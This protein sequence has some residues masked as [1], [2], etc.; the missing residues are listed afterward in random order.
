MRYLFIFG[1]NFGG[2][3]RARGRPCGV[4]PIMIAAPGWLAPTSVSALF[5]AVTIAVLAMVAYTESAQACHPV[6][7]DDPA[8]W[9][10][11]HGCGGPKPPPP[12]PGPGRPT[13]TIGRIG[14]SIPPFAVE[15]P[16]QPVPRITV[17][18]L[19]QPPPAGV[20]ALPP[21]PPPVRLAEPL[22]QPPVGVSEPEPQPA[23]DS[24]VDAAVA[25]LAAWLEVEPATIAVVTVDEV[26]W[27]DSSLG[28]PEPD[29]AYLQVLTPGLRIILA[30]NEAT[31]EYH[32]GR[33]GRV[34]L[35]ANPQPPI[36]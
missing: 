34:I 8:S 36:M 22:L 14:T 28:C 30:A 29:R 12:F 33:G 11:H 9:V 1:K 4:G 26:T 18:P 7:A 5:A 35:C 32:S 21:Q 13:P 27:R 15:P 19:P 10:G 3:A 23:P 17:Q 31:Y 24:N 25:D 20:E 2:I 6:R 16:P